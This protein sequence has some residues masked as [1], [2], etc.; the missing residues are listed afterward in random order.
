MM[1]MRRKLRRRAA[2]SPGQ[3][4]K[5]SKCSLKGSVALD[6]VMIRWLRSET[7]WR[8]PTRGGGRA[9][10][11]GNL[12]DYKGK[13]TAENSKGRQPRETWAPSAQHANSTLSDQE[14]CIDPHWGERLIRNKARIKCTQPP[15]TRSIPPLCTTRGATTTGPRRSRHTTCSEAKETL[16]S[17]GRSGVAMAERL[18]EGSS[19]FSRSD[20]K[21]P[22]LSRYCCRP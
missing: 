5:Q 16:G 10:R 18:E 15:Y 7:G 6:K 2:C 22:S 4:I 11:N 19:P 12:N 17:V 21:C 13:P 20:H 3:S 1:R 8:I 9:T 14:I